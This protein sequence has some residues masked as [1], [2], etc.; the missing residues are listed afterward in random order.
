[1][2][3]RILFRSSLQRFITR[4]SSAIEVWISL[5]DLAAAPDHFIFVRRNPT[6]LVP[7]IHIA[8]QLQAYT[9]VQAVWSIWSFD[10]VE[11]TA[12]IISQLLLYR[13]V[14]NTFQISQR[15]GVATSINL[16]TLII[17]LACLA[18]TTI[19]A[20]VITIRVEKD[21]RPRFYTIDKLFSILREEEDKP[22]SRSLWTSHTALIGRWRELYGKEP[23]LGPIKQATRHASPDT[24]LQA[25]SSQHSQPHR[26]FPH[27]LS[28]L[29]KNQI[30]DH[31]FPRLGNEYV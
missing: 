21:E 3:A 28:E 18:L 6:A 16:F 13:A 12:L 7:R 29:D 5:A 31:C 1:M 8:D 27:T 9:M 17:A 11:Q 2:C 23:K 4:Y 10:F 14:N 24:K 15:K 30:P 26:V 22:D 19:P 20:G 25:S